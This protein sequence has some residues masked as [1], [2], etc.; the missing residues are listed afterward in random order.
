MA[1]FFIFQDEHIGV[2]NLDIAEV[3]SLAASDSRWTV[4]AV[5]AYDKYITKKNRVKRT[6][7]T[8]YRDSTKTKV[9]RAEWAFQSKVP[10]KKFSTLKDAQKYLAKVLKS[11]CWAGLT[12]NTQI[13]L[14]AKKDMGG[15][16]RTAGTA[17]TSGVITLCPTYGFDEYTLLHELA[18]MAGHMHHDVAFRQ[19]VLK[20]VSRF[21]GRESAKVLKAEFR[22]KGLKLS[23]S[24]KVKTPEQWLEGY[25]RMQLARS[26]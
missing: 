8:A 21:M 6:G 24:T 1:A 9:Y 15:R 11:K 7:R 13:T 18:H 14:R 22:E 25:Y 16:S 2:L 5:L 4:D 3:K 17:S 20:L 26:K 23:I 12:A 19:T 10:I